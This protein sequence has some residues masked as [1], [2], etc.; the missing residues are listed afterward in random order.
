MS[1]DR[2]SLLDASMASTVDTATGRSSLDQSQCAFDE[3]GNII[4]DIDTDATHTAQDSVIAEVIIH[5]YLF[6]ILLPL[7]G[8]HTLKC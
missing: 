2:S 3:G 1:F 5:H 6:I 7:I 4:Q 8:M